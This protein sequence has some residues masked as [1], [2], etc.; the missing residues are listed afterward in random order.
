MVVGPTQTLQGKPRYCR[1]LD[2]IAN[3]TSPRSED[4]WHSR[5][6]RHHRETPHQLCFALH[7]IP[8]MRTCQKWLS[9]A[10]AVAPFHAQIC[11]ST[12]EQTQC[13]LMRFVHVGLNL[14]N[15]CRTATS[16][17]S[18][19]REHRA[20]PLPGQDQQ[21]VKHVTDTKICER[22][23]DEYRCRLRSEK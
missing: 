1:K 17:P 21:G 7:Q 10:M 20:A 19:T 3:V 22:R 14:K 9:C 16:R 5:D 2:R 23:T 8:E 4:R 11:Q 15:K 12:P 6:R 18:A 13:D